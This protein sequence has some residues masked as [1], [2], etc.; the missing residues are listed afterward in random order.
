MTGP[1]QLVERGC[2]ALGDRTEWDAA[3]RLYYA[4]RHQGVRRASKPFPKAADFHMPLVDNA[5][6]KHKP[7]WFGQAFNSDRLATMTATRSQAEYLT[8]AA[9]EWFDWALRSQSNFQDALV[10]VIDAMLLRGRGCL[11][12][13]A[14]VREGNKLKFEAIDPQFVLMAPGADD[15]ADAD[16]FIH[17]KHLTRGQWRRDPR[18]N[19]EPGTW[20]KVCGGQENFNQ[21]WQDKQTREGVT[22]TDNSDVAVIWECWEQDADGW[23]VSMVSPQ[24]NELVREPFRC[25][26]KAADGKPSLPFFSFPLETKDSGWYSPRG[27][28]EKLGAFEMLAC[29]VINDWLDGLSFTSKPLFTAEGALPNAAAIRFAPGEILPGNVRRV[30]MGATSVE[31]PAMVNFVNQTAEQVGQMPD[32]GVGENQPNDKRTA[33]E[34]TRIGAVMD[35]GVSFNGEMFRRRLAD[36][37]R[38]CWALT[39]QYRPASLSYLAGDEAKK[40]PQEALHDAYAIQ[41]GGRA[42]QWN[43]QQAFQRAVARYQLLGAD[44]NVSH[45]AL[46]RAVLTADDPA[47]AKE[48]FVPSDQKAATEAEDEAGELLVLQSGFPCVVRPNEDHQQRLHIIASYLQKLHATGAPVDPIGQQRIQQHAAVHFAMLKQQNPQAAQQ[49]AQQMAQTEAQAQTPPQM[50]A[51]PMVAPGAGIGARMEDGGLRMEGGTLNQI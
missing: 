18:L 46:V 20:E 35:V 30:D 8:R 50:P 24:T 48:A 34:I 3:Q 36:V 41:V 16:W 38:H 37:Y 4:M 42:D 33:T 44:P 14:D 10:A 45:E 51:V 39:L 12:V 22:H 17:V 23:T 43:R 13:I 21:I 1:K 15:F 31:L 9:T 40:L 28:G 6:A 47:A 29:K 19:Q 25:P 11:K 27:L 32:F 7:F 2:K 5:I 26:Y 49:V